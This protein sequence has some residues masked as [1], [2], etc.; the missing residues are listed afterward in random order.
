MILE[1][2]TS[3][4]QLMSREQ[5]MFEIGKLWYLTDPSGKLFGV[6]V[7][8]AEKHNDDWIVTVL[9]GDEFLQVHVY[10]STPDKKGYWCGLLHYGP[11]EIN[12][13]KNNMQFRED[14][15][16]DNSLEVV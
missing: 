15:T 16:F 2:C 12:L 11:S 1:T 13:D 6:T 5:S 14:N 3:I 4:H 8:E 9:N 7:L 10:A